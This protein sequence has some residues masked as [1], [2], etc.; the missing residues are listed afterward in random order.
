M[1]D[2]LIEKLRNLLGGINVLN[3]K[4]DLLL[5]SSDA[6]IFPGVTPS[7]V[8]LPGSTREVSAV[9]KLCNEH[10]RPFV[11]EAPVQISAEGPFLRPAG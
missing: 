7:V 2:R 3:S 1:E 4:A 10:N 5:Y 6:F 9:V 11:E 8:V